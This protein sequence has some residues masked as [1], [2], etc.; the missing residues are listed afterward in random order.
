MQFLRK[1]IA[2]SLATHQER[3]LVIVNSLVRT[4]SGVAPLESCVGKFL[5]LAG[6]QFVKNIHSTTSMAKSKFEYVKQFEADDPC[7]QNCWIVVRIDG[8]AF[9]KFTDVH[10]YA[11]PNDDRGLGLMTKAAQVVMKEFNEIVL[12]YGQSDEYSFVFN[13]QAKVYN[14]RASKIM[15]NVVSLFAS[16]FT[17]HWSS[18]FDQQQ[19]Q[20]PPSFDARIVLYPSDDNLKDYL[21][22]RQADCHINNLYNTC[23]WTLIQEKG[24]TPAESQ[25]RLKGTLS[26][27][28]NEILFSEFNIN[29]NNL[30]E[31]YRKGSVLIRPKNRAG[32]DTVNSTN[33][34]ILHTDI[35]GKSFWEEYPYI[36]DPK[37]LSYSS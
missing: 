24:L 6:L 19:L 8:K 35:I 29:Y 32:V 31:L 18:Y 36:L 4:L 5:G 11:K 16:S 22:W 27:D 12:S 34:V 13:K 20:Y 17:F 14:R 23:F 26:G 2:T 25:E 3:N 37:V 7:L 1:Y 33:S 15:T 30:P 21:S 10:Q 28:K 9:H